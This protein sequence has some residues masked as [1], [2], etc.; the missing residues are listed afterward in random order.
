[1]S[2][3]RLPMEPDVE[4]VIGDGRYERGDAESDKAIKIWTFLGSIGWL[5]IREF[6]RRARSAKGSEGSMRIVALSGAALLTLALAGMAASPANAQDE[7]AVFSE[8]EIAD[9]VAPIALYPDSLLAEVLVAATYPLEVIKADRFIDDT[10]DLSD[11]DRA[12]AAEA[13]GWDP[14]VV[15]LAAGFPTVVQRMA[16]EIDWTEDLGDAMTLQ[17]EDVLDAVQ[18]MRA[19]ASAAGTLASNEAQVVEFRDDAISIAPADP[20][21]IYVPTYDT[22]TVYAAQP[23]YATAPATPVYT[24]V[25]DRYP[26][27]NLL[28]TG[29]VAFGTAMLVDEIFDDDDNYNGRNLNDYWRPDDRNFDWDE[30]DFNRRPNINVDGDVNVNVKGDSVD[31]RRRREAARDRLDADDKWKSSDE[32]K[33]EARDRLAERKDREKPGA[34]PEKNKAQKDSKDREQLQARL[35]DRQDR[36]DAGAARDKLKDRPARDESAARDKLKD[37]TDKRKPRDPSKPQLG[38]KPDGA[39]NPQNLARPANRDKT[40]LADNVAKRDRAKDIES[41]LKPQKKTPAQ[42]DRAKDRA[43]VSTKD[44]VKRPDQPTLAAAKHKPATAKPE[45]KKPTAKPS[46]F[47]PAQKSAAKERKANDRGSA[48]VSRER[49]KPKPVLHSNRA[50]S[51]RRCRL[52]AAATAE[53]IA[54]SSETLSM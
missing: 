48:S 50:A 16:D 42:L 21:I 52:T 6:G 7:E 41:A 19:R 53:A 18:L 14:S 27:S 20:Q 17:T 24:S 11:P 32:R 4:G 44:R 5:Q 23:T 46:A 2:V 35:K 38:D 3:R 39:R 37:S 43:S 9:L 49:A 51:M 29:A 47:K 54:L 13:E 36:P 26:T 34:R 10:A 31:I 12:D 33:K 30:G 28:T 15:V 22:Q 1:M 45:A 40:E 25:E 8:D